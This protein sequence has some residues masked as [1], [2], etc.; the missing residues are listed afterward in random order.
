L[1]KFFGQAWILFQHLSETVTG[2]PPP[3]HKATKFFDPFARAGEVHSVTEYVE[4]LRDRVND[5]D[6]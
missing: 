2:I 4:I 6:F 5:Q 3:I 1:S